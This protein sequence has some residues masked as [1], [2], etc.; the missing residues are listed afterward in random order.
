MSALNNKES[1]LNVPLTGRQII[2]R[3]PKSALTPRRA[4][5]KNPIFEAST[6]EDQ[7]EIYDIINPGGNEGDILLTAR[8]PSLLAFRNKTIKA[9]PQTAL[10]SARDKRRRKK[11]AVE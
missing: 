7:T 11:E 10:T 6:V 3:P 9:R 5:K 4:G 8:S 2:R 1:N